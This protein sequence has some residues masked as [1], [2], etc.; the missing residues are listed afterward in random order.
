MNTSTNIQCIKCKKNYKNNKTLELHMKRMH[1]EEVEPEVEPD[2]A[3]EVKTKEEQNHN[4]DT[5]IKC[6]NELEYYKKL[7][8]KLYTRYRN[9]EKQVEILMKDFLTQ[10][11]MKDYNEKNPENKITEEEFDEMYKVV[12]PHIIPRSMC[13]EII[14]ELDTTIN[15]R[16]KDKCITKEDKEEIKK[17][18]KKLLQ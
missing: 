7:S 3:P 1:N 16:Y 18:V 4:C 6:K 5:C 10:K 9:T 13:L 11:Y 14:N 8:D 2:F 17:K 15:N 12:Y